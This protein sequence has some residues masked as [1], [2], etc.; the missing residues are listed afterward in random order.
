M[1]RTG[2][3]AEIRRQDRYRRRDETSVTLGSS[4]I[5]GLKRSVCGE[6]PRSILGILRI[7]S[8]RKRERK[9][10]PVVHNVGNCRIN[11]WCVRRYVLASG[12]RHFWR[13]VRGR[14][15]LR[16]AIPLANTAS[17]SGVSFVGF[18]AQLFGNSPANGLETTFVDLTEC[19]DDSVAALCSAL[20]S[21][22]LLI[23][24]APE[25]PWLA[26]EFHRQKFHRLFDIVRGA[27][28]NFPQ[29]TSYASSSY[30]TTPCVN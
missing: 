25:I 22:R 9:H 1:V 12:I 28:N 26:Q 7:E 13:P 29:V 15:E 21:P 17:R 6:R 5:V 30:A 27:R 4:K 18:F 19:A 11:L 10:S 24:L 14:S 2:V 8:E 23:S 20:L 16:S 3:L